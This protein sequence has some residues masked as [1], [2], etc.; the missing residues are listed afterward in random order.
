MSCHLWLRLEGARCWEEKQLMGRG[1][2]LGSELPETGPGPYSWPIRLSG[3]FSRASHGIWGKGF[4]VYGGEGR[5]H[6]GSGVELTYCCI[7]TDQHHRRPP[8]FCQIDETSYIYVTNGNVT[9]VE[10]V[11]RDGFYRC[12]FLRFIAQAFWII[13]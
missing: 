5:P 7:F 1:Y 13:C 4:A 2:G 11:F 10:H 9:T 6:W 8:S 12:Y 3:H